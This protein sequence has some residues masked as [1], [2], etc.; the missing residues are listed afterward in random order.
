VIHWKPALARPLPGGHNRNGRLAFAGRM[1]D[2]LDLPGGQ[3]DFEGSLK[4]AT[5]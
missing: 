2:S 4:G 1:R 5:S 3:F